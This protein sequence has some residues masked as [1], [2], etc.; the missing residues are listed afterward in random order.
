[1][2]K[3]DYWSNVDQ[4]GPDECWLW[5]GRLDEHGYGRVGK[6]SIPAHR[7][8][9]EECVGPI[10]DGLHTDHLCHTHDVS[11]PGGASCLHRRCVNPRHIEP[12]TRKENILRGRNFAA[13]NAAKTHCPQGHP[14]DE[15]N[16]YVYVRPGARARFCRTCLR[17]GKRRLETRVT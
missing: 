6:R 11:C 14:Y 3:I 16:T 1:M 5:T 10:P 4:R 7:I 15:A 17:A 13:V 2:P 12:V 8:A 9:Y